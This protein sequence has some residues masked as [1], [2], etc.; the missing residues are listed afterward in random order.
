MR[1]SICYFVILMLS[2]SSCANDRLQNG[3][4]FTKQGVISGSQTDQMTC[5]QKSNAVWV[6]VDGAQECIRYFSSGLKDKNPSALFHIHG[7]VASVYYISARV[8]EVV[9]GYETINEQY[10]N[11]ITRNHA[12]KIDQPFIFVSRPGTFG[13]S[14]HHGLRLQKINLTLINRAI[15]LIKE[16]HHIDKIS[17]S[18][19]SGGGRVVSALLNWRNDIDCAALASSAGSFMDTIRASNPGQNMDMFK[20]FIYDPAEDINQMK[21]DSNRHIYVIAD[22]EDDRVK[23]WAQKSYFDRVKKLGH[24]IDILE[25]KATDNTHHI[26]SGYGVAVANACH[27]KLT[28]AE[29]K[30]K[31]DGVAIASIFKLNASSYS[32]NVKKNTYT[33]PKM[34]PVTTINYNGQSEISW[35]ES[36]LYKADV[37]L[38]EGAN[39]FEVK[40]LSPKNKYQGCKGTFDMRTKANGKWH[41]N[42]DKAGPAS[43]DIF[44]DTANNLYSFVG[45]DE[46]AQTI[47]FDFQ[48]MNK[49]TKTKSTEF[50]KSKEI[51]HNSKDKPEEKSDFIKK[52]E[53]SLIWKGD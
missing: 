7:D 27:D 47:T 8:Q 31:F 30:K 23:H 19:Q 24:N 28:A 38:H 50:I 10:L 36:D 40:I 16:K 1:V 46:E 9:S 14:G 29:I 4:T 52:V 6:Q 42:C 11:S 2:L 35:G 39:K 5:N 41:M 49:S 3:N 18:G 44:Y 13:S 22:K 15:D 20:N 12:Q 32:P 53:R 51:A 45:H 25:F 43:G 21:H 48:K 34:V 33:V 37:S 17:L 26:L